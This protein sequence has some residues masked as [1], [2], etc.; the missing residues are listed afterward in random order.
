MKT[1]KIP[2]RKIIQENQFFDDIAN[3][4]ENPIYNKEK[5]K[6][7]KNILNFAFKYGIPTGGIVG[8]L[9]DYM[10]DGNEYDSNGNII[11]KEPLTNGLLNG[12]LAGGLGTASYGLNNNHK[13]I[14]PDN[15]S[16]HYTKT[17]DSIKFASPYIKTGYTKTKDSINAGINLS[18]EFIK[19]KLNKN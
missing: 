2:L 3:G 12:M 6:K 19:T 13:I 8:G 1:I 4:N 14:T 18:K 11:N 9:T 17:K 10:Y 5:L 15:I 7:D 16:K